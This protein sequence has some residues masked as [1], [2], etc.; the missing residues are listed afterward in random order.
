M[1]RT[2]TV[3]LVGTAMLASALSACSVSYSSKTGSNSAPPP[4]APTSSS[5]ATPAAT[6]TEAP[7]KSAAVLKGDS[8]QIPGNIVFD[9]GKATLKAGEQ[10]EQVLEQ[11]KLYLDENAQVT[12][13]RIEGHT[14]N[15]GTPEDN[16][17]LS[18]ARALTIKK[19]LIDHG[20]AKER[21]LA[22][23]FGD[24]RPIAD[25]STEE[26]RAQN[27]RTEFKLATI[28]NKKYLGRDPSAGGKVFDQ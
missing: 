12:Q 21:L 14:D 4:P 11:L 18:G 23:G 3:A 16:L 5:A 10:S 7:A 27:R 24:T 19:W 2:R 6:A 28:E 15:V 25:N 22:V 9:F 1:T 8:V 26:G 13:L 17:N 20:V